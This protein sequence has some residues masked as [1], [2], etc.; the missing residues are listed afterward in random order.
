M[1]MVFA[2]AVVAAKAAPPGGEESGSLAAPRP[3]WEVLFAEEIS[4]EEYARQLDFFKI[5]IA[6]VSKNN[7]I[8]YI[9]KLSGRKPEKRVGRR[10][11]DARVYVGWKSG[12]LE[13]VD[14]KLFAK[15][16]IN[17]QRKEILHFIPAES[18]ALMEEAQRSYADRQP[19]EIE[20]TRF[21]IHPRESGGY[22]F[23]VVEQDPRRR[24]RADTSARRLLNP[25]A[26]N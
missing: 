2:W 8:E 22:E 20:R 6:A 23:V 18:Q 15:A 5:E 11:E 21:E 4:P 17:S 16:R 3:H 10:E 26:E 25:P 7:K 1:L 24:Q 19:D 13:A 14:R 9:S 12:T